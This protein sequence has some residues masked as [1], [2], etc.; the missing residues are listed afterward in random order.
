MKAL[1]CTIKL[2]NLNLK[3]IYFSVVMKAA[4]RTELL[5][6]VRKEY[7]KYEKSSDKL[8]SI[9]VVSC[10]II[11]NTHAYRLENRILQTS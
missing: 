3:K 2:S 6:K 4:N 1:D 9:C 7:K 8:E 11:K 5:D 10:K